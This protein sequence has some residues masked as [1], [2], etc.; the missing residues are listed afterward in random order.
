VP[1]LADVLAWAR[2]HG[3]RVN[4]ELKSDVSRPHVLLRNVSRVARASGVGPE[5]VLFSSFNPAFV[6]ALRLLAREFPRAWLIDRGRS[7][8]QRAPGFRLL[9]DGVNPHHE[10]V[11]ATRIA[12]WRR[13]GALLATWTVNDP[14]EARRV[15]ALGVDS[16]IS[17]EPGK[18]LSALRG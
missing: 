15:A 17:D 1:L 7:F 14:D 9:A 10:L 12:R 16:I 6:A 18:I 13:R 4:V 8:V 5:L 3:Q 2:T 11:T